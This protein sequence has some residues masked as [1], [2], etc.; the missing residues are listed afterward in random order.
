MEQRNF[1]LTLNLLN[2]I[3]TI[4]CGVKYGI[5]TEKWAEKNRGERICIIL[6][7]IA[8]GSFGI[9][10]VIVGLVKISSGQTSS[11]EYLH[12]IILGVGCGIASLFER[13]D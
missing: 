7:L 1:Y 12:N 9:S 8:W 4:C 6:W 11:D 10:L 2:L 3:L 5:L 13:R